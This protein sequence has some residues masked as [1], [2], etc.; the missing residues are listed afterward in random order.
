L[1]YS[2]CLLGQD[3]IDVA[4]GLFAADTGFEPQAIVLEKTGILIVGFGRELVAIDLAWARIRFRIDF[5]TYFREMIYLEQACILAFEE[6]GVSAIS[7]KGE[8]RWTFTK[9]V[10]TGIVLEGHDLRLE[11]MDSP[12]VVVNVESG[13]VSKS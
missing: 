11:F 5:E 4:V 12:P 3:K 10:I 13:A 1:T 7:L 6:I 2:S 8:K 9:D